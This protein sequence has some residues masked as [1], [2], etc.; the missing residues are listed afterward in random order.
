M[1]GR[2]VKLARTVQMMS[3][4]SL[5]EASGI[6]YPYLSEIENDKKSPSPKTL[7]AISKALGVK[8]HELM[9]TA[10]RLQSGPTDS[11][12]S[13]MAM[14]QSEEIRPAP[15]GWFH[16]EPKSETKPARSSLSAEVIRA[17]EELSDDDLQIV[18]QLVERLRAKS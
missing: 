14:T 8:P 3:R 18:M 9:E 5:A 7:N 10:D 4:K 13:Y 16:E 17:L 1:V 6:S 15:A 12:L 11:P 2:A